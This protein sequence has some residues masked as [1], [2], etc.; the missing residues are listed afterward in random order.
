MTVAVD[1]SGAE[2]HA[3]AV[4]SE[5]QFQNHW[6]HK[7]ML[8]AFIITLREGFEAALMLGITLV[9][10]GKIGR[11]ALRKAAYFTLASAFLTSIALAILLSRAHYNQDVFDGWVTLVAAFL[12]VPLMVFT[13][14]TGLRPKGQ[15]EG[16]NIL[17]GEGSRFELFLLVSLMAFAFLMILREGMETVLILSA[18][19]MSLPPLLAFVGTL[20]GVGVSV[21]LG[22]MLVK[23][24]TRINFRNSFRFITVILFFTGTQLTVSGL[25]ALSAFS[26]PSR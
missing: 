6:S 23:S 8:Q 2:Y 11:P 12:V 1:E 9:C 14:K 3:C 17:A 18:V 4:E 19:S 16:E 7:L 24:S 26:R 25:H 15:I 22:A 5:F 21:L 20:L 10:L 13:T